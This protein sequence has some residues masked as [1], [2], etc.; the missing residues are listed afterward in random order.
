[1]LTKL[2]QNLLD[3]LRILPFWFAY[4]YWFLWIAGIALVSI[5]FVHLTIKFIKYLQE[6]R[7]E[8]EFKLK[9]ERRF[10]KVQLQ[11]ALANIKDET[12]KNKNFRQGLHRISS[13]LKT[14]YEILLKKEI[15]EMTASEIKANIKEKKDLGDFFTELV[16]IQFASELPKE[17]DFISYYNQSVKITS[18]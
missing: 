14:Y 11:H 4:L 1:M 15:E 12:L 3:P 7:E 10:S 17:Q 9:E 2:P 6:Q 8:K 5:L 16:V 13:V 18:E